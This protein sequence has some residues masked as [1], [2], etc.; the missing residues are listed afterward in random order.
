MYIRYQSN[1]RVRKFPWS[2]VKLFIFKPR[3]T[4]YLPISGNVNVSVA[5][6]HIS[7]VRGSKRGNLNDIFWSSTRFEWHRISRLS[8]LKEINFH[9]ILFCSS[10]L[11]PLT[12]PRGY[13][14]SY[15]LWRSIFYPGIEIIFPGSRGKS[16]VVLRG[17]NKPLEHEEKARK[18]V[19]VL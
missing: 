19:I 18:H 15:F 4:D 12:I 6:H 16:R 5:L 7:G 1:V 10:H 17:E 2:L 8:V 11:S 14:F 3:W 13:W 9:I